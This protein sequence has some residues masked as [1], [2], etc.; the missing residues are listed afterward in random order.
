M[1]C[2]IH[3]YTVCSKLNNSRLLV[4]R[5]DWCDRGVSFCSDD[6]QQSWGGGAVLALRPGDQPV[7]EVLERGPLREV[8]I[9][10][11]LAVHGCVQSH[12]AQA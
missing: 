7:S 2:A 9:R 5:L 1:C 8:G 6:L 3:Y 4:A 12:T 11:P 10:H